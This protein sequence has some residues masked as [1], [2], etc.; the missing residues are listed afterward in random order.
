MP[1]SLELLGSRAIAQLGL[2]AE[3]EQGL[4]AA[5]CAPSAGN[6]QHLVNG[7]IRSLAATRRMRKGAVVTHIAAEL[8]ER[9][10]DLAG[11]GNHA[12]MRGITP[13]RSHLHE[14]GKIAIDQRQCLFAAEIA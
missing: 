5:S 11:I 8:G 6:A 7:Q 13:A 12:T 1:E 3:R 14:R 9:D 2:V 4:L 10:K